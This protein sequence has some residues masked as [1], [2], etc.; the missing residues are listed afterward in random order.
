MPNNYASRRPADKAAK[1][2]K[3]LLAWY[4]AHHRNL[5]W[6]QSQDPYRIWVSEI[7]LQQTQVNTV[8]GY[9]NRFM[10]KFPDIFR[11]AAADLQDVLKCWEGLGYY[12]R[13]RNLHKAARELVATADGRIPD[14]WE[15][16]RKL[17]G[18]GDYVAA[19]V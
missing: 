7:M 13:A 4:Q 18:V 9:F 10:V 19:A 17:P 16:L 15:A 6:R 8:I 3:A 2:Q 1:I 5:P 14:E 11:L 12:A